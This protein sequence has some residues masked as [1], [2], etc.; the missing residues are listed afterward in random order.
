MHP[1]YRVPIS[2]PDGKPYPYV[3]YYFSTAGAGRDLLLTFH[4]RCGRIRTALG[5]RYT[6]GLAL[7]TELSAAQ[8]TPASLYE[9]LHDT[10]DRLTA[11]AVTLTTAL[12]A[13]R[14][15]KRS[16][17]LFIDAS[18]RPSFYTEDV[19]AHLSPISCGICI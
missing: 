7:D 15:L 3:G 8:I 19:H 6:A 14:A 18:W 17:A 4:S 2:T 12:Q 13:E 1:E 11:D 9:M 16:A 10:A 5:G